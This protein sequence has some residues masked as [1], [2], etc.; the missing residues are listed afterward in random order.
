MSRPHRTMLYCPGNNP[1]MMKDIHI[2]GADAIMFDLEDA[3]PVTEKDSA[4]LMTYHALRSFDY[5][6]TERVVRINGLDTPYGEEDV[7]AM[8]RA[9]PDIIRL[10]K[11]ESAQDIHAIDALIAE[12][13]RDCGRP[14]GSQKIMAA[15]ETALGVIN[16]RE[17]VTASPRLVGV[18][19]GAED[20]VTD[21]RTHRSPE[22][23]ELLYARSAIL[24]AGRAAGLFVVDTVYSDVDNEEGFR[25]EVRL[26]KQLGFDGKSVI[27][28]RQIDH[29]HELFAPTE[30]EIRHASRTLSALQEAEAK[31]VGVLTVNGKMVDKAMIERARRVLDLARVSGLPVEEEC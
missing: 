15:V 22:G 6:G 31:G 24:N 2:Y 17:I 7:Q 14:V 18:A 10:P 29:V 20:Y 19:L 3:I 12:V 23:I 28:P 4:R 21:L 30:K 8:V 27:N 1:A 25:D 5:E 11:T 16:I 9:C 26:I 13:E